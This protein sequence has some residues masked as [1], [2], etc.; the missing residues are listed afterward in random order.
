MSE[1]IHTGILGDTSKE[2]W[3]EARRQNEEQRRADA[4]YVERLA[5]QQRL[6]DRIDAAFEPHICEQL[7][8]MEKAKQKAV[9]RNK[10]RRAED[11]IIFEEFRKYCSTAWNPPLPALPA[12]PAAVAEPRQERQGTMRRRLPWR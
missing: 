11:R 12:A 2:A 3:A 9:K 4:E 7:E 1:T 8:V 10:K 5:D 6:L